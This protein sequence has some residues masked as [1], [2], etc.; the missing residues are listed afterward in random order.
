MLI[1]KTF[2]INNLK[3]LNFPEINSKA[4][5]NYWKWKKKS[6]GSVR[7]RLEQIIFKYVAV[8]KSERKKFEQFMI[9]TNYIISYGIIFALIMQSLAREFI[10][11]VDRETTLTT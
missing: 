10:N 1:Q 5:M 3:N 9:F 7:F 11:G 2:I 4:R 8:E 6:E